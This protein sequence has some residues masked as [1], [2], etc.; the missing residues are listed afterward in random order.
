MAAH[1]VCRHPCGAT[2]RRSPETGGR[3][4]PRRDGLFAKEDDGETTKLSGSSSDGRPRG[5]RVRTTAKLTPRWPA[6]Q[7]LRSQRPPENPPS[8]AP[9]HIHFAR[10]RKGDSEHSQLARRRLSTRDLCAL[11]KLSSGALDADGHQLLVALLPVPGV[12]S[13]LARETAVARATGFRR[14]VA[15][16]ASCGSLPPSRW[17]SHRT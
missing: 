17:R 12:R 2:T 10:S 8:A 15:L 5:R 1:G 14:L 11:P 3:S 16:P 9:F 13:A 4:R 7:V 6:K